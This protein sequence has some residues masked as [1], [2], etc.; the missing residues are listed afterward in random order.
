MC[1]S[2]CLLSLLLTIHEVLVCIR[3]LVLRVS[4][5]I[6]RFLVLWLS[7]WFSSCNQ[8]LLRNIR[9]FLCYTMCL[10]VCSSFV[11]VERV[12]LGK[13]RLY[14]CS[15]KQGSYI[16]SVPLKGLVK[17]SGY[18]KRRWEFKDGWLVL[19]AF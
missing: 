12:R 1:C 11:S 17:L 16:A 14:V 18:R 15:R 10:Y 3:R 5:S 9:V 2:L 7:F 6:P 19:E 4:G 8:W 13:M